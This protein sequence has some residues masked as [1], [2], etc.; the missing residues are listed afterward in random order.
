MS[1]SKTLFGAT[2]QVPTRGEKGWGTEM[3]NIT[4]QLVDF[5]NGIGNLV[6]STAFFNLSVASVTGTAGG[7]ITPTCNLL[8]LSAAGPVTL[9]NSLPL[10]N[11]TT[12]MPNLV[13]IVGTSDTNTITIE[14]GGNIKLNGD[15]VIGQGDTL[16][17]VWDNTSLW[18]ELS[19]NN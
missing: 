7:T 3:T 11:R 13:A 10:A 9:S 8:I 1:V 16:L 5:A 14:D 17:L 18:V 6:G 15:I 12:G 4:S 19:R 2:V